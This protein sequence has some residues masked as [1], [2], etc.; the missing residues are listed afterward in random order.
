MENKENISINYLEIIKKS[1][2]IVRKNRYLWWLGFFMAFSG[3]SIWMFNFSSSGENNPQDL[4]KVWNFISANLNWIIPLIIFLI[5]L[6]IFLMILGTFARAGI[7]K[8]T[9]KIEK[10]EIFGFKEA[11]IEGKKYFWKF[12]F[13]GAILSVVLFLILAVMA[14]PIILLFIAKSYVIGGILTFIAILIFIPLAV[15]FAFIKIYGQIYLILGKI[16][17][18]AS[19]E[20][21]YRLFLKNILKSL[22]MALIFIPLSILMSFAV[23]SLAIMLVIIFGIPGVLLFLVLKT[24][25]IIIAAG[26]AA[27]A[28]IFLVLVISSF[29]QSFSQIIWV[30]FFK[31]IAAPKVEEVLKEIAEEEVLAQKTPEPAG[32]ITTSKID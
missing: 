2:Q 11:M 21:A 28:F 4:E 9:E 17:L 27:L 15:I 24:T 30:L 29:F 16:S 18:K 14:V 6:F 22:I 8:A 19:I 26:L 13:L 23:L 5:L 20:N 3:G 7:I 32:G 1:F 25:G 12:F 31:E 10:K